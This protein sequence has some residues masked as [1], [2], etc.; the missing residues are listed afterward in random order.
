[1][2]VLFKN[3]M[4]KY[5]KHIINNIL[6]II[7]IVSFCYFGGSVLFKFEEVGLIASLILFFSIFKQVFFDYDFLKNIEIILAAPVSL[8]D[9]LK[10]KTK[11]IFA[12]LIPQTLVLLIGLYTIY[13][14]INMKLAL[15]IIFMWFLFIVIS[16]VLGRLVLIYMNDF[17]VK[18]TIIEVAVISLII[19]FL[20]VSVT[21]LVFQY[22][23]AIF[24][25]IYLAKNN[26]YFDKEILI[27]RSI[28][29]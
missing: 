29:L 26:V 4:Y 14:T 11:Y 7:T 20:K 1:M 28:K 3:E 10:A 21:I 12:L 2:G 15:Y 19:V 18:I 16:L 27:N 8:L 9:I 25:G 23:I 22:I 24:V 5:K 17:K 6:T 13:K